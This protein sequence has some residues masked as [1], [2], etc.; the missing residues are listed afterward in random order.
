M[1]LIKERTLKK[2]RDTRQPQHDQA[3]VNKIKELSTKGYTQKSIA[4]Y[5]NVA[6][7]T[8]R[9]MLKGHYQTKEQYWERLANEKLEGLSDV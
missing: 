9:A 7:E 4:A 2:I 5:F 1:Q 6:V 3:R 8:V